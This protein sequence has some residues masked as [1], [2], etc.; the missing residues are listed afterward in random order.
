MLYYYVL[1]LLISIEFIIA[2]PII[3]IVDIWIICQ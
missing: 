2:F 1:M 3:E